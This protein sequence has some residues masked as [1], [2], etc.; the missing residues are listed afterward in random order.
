MS[1]VTMFIL[2]HS[3]VQ[4]L[5]ALNLPYSENEILKIKEELKNEL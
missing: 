1:S 3:L 2:K 4:T 5:K